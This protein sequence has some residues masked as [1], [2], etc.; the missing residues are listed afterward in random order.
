MKRALVVGTD[1]YRTFRQ[2]R[3]C[4]NDARA[5]SALVARHEDGTPDFDCHLLA[6]SIAGVDHDSLR[7]AIEHLLSGGADVAL[8]YAAGHGLV[9]DGELTLVTTDGTSQTPGVGLNDILSIAARSEIRE[10]ILILDCCFSGHAGRVPQLTVDT[11]VLRPGLVILTATRADEPAVETAKR[12]G[13]FSTMLCAGLE[14][15]AA[16]VL[17][18]VTIGGLYAYLSECF[19]PW[20]QRPMLKANI[21]REGELRRCRPSV[22]VDELRRLPELFPTP[23]QELPLDPSYEPDAEPRNPGHERD[24]ALLQRARAAKLVEPV[25]TEHLYF[26]A[27]NSLS[28]RLTPLGQHYRRMAQRGWL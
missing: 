15:G 7:R 9:R 23:G 16:D 18:K 8:L 24:F 27:M 2:L 26:A 3:G 1:V 6:D 17:G 12:R 20:D 14:G 28:C 25:G 21:E 13:L 5:V 4:V 22:P 10:I 11:A 19:G